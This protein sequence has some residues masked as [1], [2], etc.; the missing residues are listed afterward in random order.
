MAN[1]KLL[2][3][4]HNKT[5]RNKVIADLCTGLQICM[6]VRVCMRVCARVCACETE[7]RGGESD[8]K[9]IN[10]QIDKRRLGD[11]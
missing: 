10:G 9:R 11:R 5:N 8:D 2:N 4:L 7:E 1:Y 3:F 6:H